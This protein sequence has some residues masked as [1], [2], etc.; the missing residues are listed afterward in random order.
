MSR[1]TPRKKFWASIFRRPE[2]ALVLALLS[3]VPASAAD[4]PYYALIYDF[5]VANFCNLVGKNVY[6]TFWTKRRALEAASERPTDA[7]TR[8]RVR[9]M[10]AADREYQNRGLGGHRQW[11]QAEGLAGVGRIL[12]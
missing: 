5:E 11:C 8:T 12:E 1:W 2:A 6:D 7:L 4:D 10:A 3:S 9:A